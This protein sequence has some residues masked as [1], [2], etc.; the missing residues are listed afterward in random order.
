MKPRSLIGCML[1]SAILICGCTYY[2]SS[3]SKDALSMDNY[4]ALLEEYNNK[5]VLIGNTTYT[6]VQPMPIPTPRPIFYYDSP[7]M[8]NILQDY[9]IN[10]NDSFKILLGKISSINSPTAV[11]YIGTTLAGEYGPPYSL[12]GIYTLPCSIEN[13][14]TIS[15]I[16]KNGTILAIANNKAICLK[17]GENFT[18]IIGHE[19]VTGSYFANIANKSIYDFYMNPTQMPWPVTNEVSITIT[20]EGIF[21]KSILKS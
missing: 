10:V 8:S 20:N 14:L 2:G 19:N 12:S 1:I 6:P 5:S 17:P 9:S 21:D 18:F 11:G 3:S 13:A 16:S 7:G 4:V 15:S